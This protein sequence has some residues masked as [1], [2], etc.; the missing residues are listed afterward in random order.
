[1]IS[2]CT[3]QRE[4]CRDEE[5][6]AWQYG[7]HSLL[8]VDQDHHSCMQFA[9]THT[10]SVTSQPNFHLFHISL[11]ANDTLF[12]EQFLCKCKITKDSIHSAIVSV[13]PERILMKQWLSAWSWT[14]E[15]TDS[16]QHIR[17]RLNLELP[18][19]TRFRVYLYLSHLEYF[20]KSAGSNLYL[21]KLL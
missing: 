6:R 10:V 8:Y 2:H 17:I 11:L 7:S 16:G 19:W 1:M 18:S 5:S 13:I 9:L 21:H 3:G 14:A 15:D 20:L 12:P 4:D